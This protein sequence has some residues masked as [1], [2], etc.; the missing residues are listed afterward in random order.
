MEKP[1]VNVSVIEGRGKVQDM[2]L[3]KG[4]HFIIPAS[5]KECLFEGD[6]T[7]IVSYC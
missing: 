4:D 6:M 3:K 1:F 7:V 5:L 2:V